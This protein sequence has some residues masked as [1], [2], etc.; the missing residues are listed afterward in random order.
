MKVATVRTNAKSSAGARRDS[1][2]YPG[3]CPLKKR[4]DAITLVRR[5]SSGSGPV[6][7]PTH[8]DCDRGLALSGR[9]DGGREARLMHGDRPRTRGRSPLGADRPHAEP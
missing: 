2:D 3:S 7:L 8:G 4:L 9:V 6:R 5:M 1:P